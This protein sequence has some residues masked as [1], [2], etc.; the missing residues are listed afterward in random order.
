MA[1]DQ[2][3]DSINTD[4]IWETYERLGGRRRTKSTEEE[5]LKRDVELAKAGEIT[6]DEIGTGAYDKRVLIDNLKKLNDGLYL[7]GDITYNEAQYE[8]QECMR[9][10]E[11]L[12]EDE[13]V[14]LT[15]WLN[16]HDFDVLGKIAEFVKSGGGYTD[17]LEKYKQYRSSIN[18]SI[19]E[20]DFIDYIL[21]YRFIGYYLDLEESVYD[22]KI[23]ECKSRDEYQNDLYSFIIM[24]LHMLSEVYK[25]KWFISAKV[26]KE[27]IYKD[28][29]EYVLKTTDKSNQSI[30]KL[31]RDKN[32]LNDV[33]SNC[34]D[35]LLKTAYKF[36]L[37][38]IGKN[39][40]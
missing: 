28:K 35:D 23:R 15:S 17:G 21:K 18:E 22:E 6:V 9:D 25:P 16:M 11:K 30:I 37:E 39:I 26:E 14:E 5:I 40:E 32:L 2:D 1:N 4:W 29:F 19:N 12:A 34:N 3:K 24:R 8:F 27:E 31:F 20:I 10:V 7:T 33:V 36:Y 38:D 13:G